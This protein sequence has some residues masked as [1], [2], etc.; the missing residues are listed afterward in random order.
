MK[1][2]TGVGCTWLYCMQDVQPI[3]VFSLCWVPE[4]GPKLENHATIHLQLPINHKSLN[5]VVSLFQCAFQPGLGFR[6][7]GYECRCLR[8]FFN[9]DA[10][11][12]WTGFPGP[13]TELQPQSCVPCPEECGHCAGGSAECLA[14]LDPTLRGALLAVESLCMGAT[15]GLAIAVFRNRKRK[16]SLYCRVT[17]GLQDSIRSN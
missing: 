14:R 2:L 17:S 1:V 11:V 3:Y 10:S 6:S 16:V 15:V 7:G 9:P 12:G 13:D 4:V 5:H 8:G